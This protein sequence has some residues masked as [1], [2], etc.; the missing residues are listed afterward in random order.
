M[1]WPP[2]CSRWPSRL[3]SDE[4]PVLAAPAR[5]GHAALPLV[6]PSRRPSSPLSPSELQKPAAATTAEPAATTAEPE[7]TGAPGATAQSEAHSG[8]TVPRTR[9]IALAC[10]TDAP[11]GGGPVAFATASRA[12]VVLLSG[13]GHA[14]LWL[15]GGTAESTRAATGDSTESATGA[16]GGRTPAA[17]IGPATA[18]STSARA[19]RAARA[20]TGDS[21]ESARATRS[22][23]RAATRSAARATGRRGPAAG[24][25]PA[26]TESTRTSWIVHC[27]FYI[28]HDKNKTMYHS[29][30][31]RQTGGFA[32]GQTGGA[33]KRKP[34]TKCKKDRARNRC[35]LSTRTTDSRLCRR[36]AKGR[37]A[38]AHPTIAPAYVPKPGLSAKD[39][40]AARKAHN[41]RMRRAVYNGKYKKTRGGLTRADLTISAVSGKVVSKKQAAHGR[42]MW[43]QN[44]DEMNTPFGAAAAP[45]KLKGIGRKHSQATR[46]VR[47][48]RPAARRSAAVDGWVPRGYE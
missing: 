37:C 3:N 12:P 8:N 42:R 24:V 22:A 5:L 15:P 26:T 40:A 38:V 43:A 47:P 14:S 20:A 1:R 25:S 41:S 10:E 18:E 34:R 19:A 33:R 7:S 30:Y 9:A 31:A 45:K 35:V 27:F 46:I 44:H 2:R 17:R 29:S 48:S 4:A 32:F 16:T 6:L 23:A 36:T 39:Q 13:R 28:S 21:T 11:N